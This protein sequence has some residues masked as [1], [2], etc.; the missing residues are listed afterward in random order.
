M[1]TEG[2][3]GGVLFFFLPHQRPIIA[4]WFQKFHLKNSTELLLLIQT[5]LLCPE[6]RLRPPPPTPTAYVC[7]TAAANRRQQPS[8]SQHFLQATLVRLERRYFFLSDETRQYL[9]SRRDNF[10]L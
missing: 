7:Q 8:K 4:I 1:Q 5:A 9:F 10:P 3:P 6:A 2:P